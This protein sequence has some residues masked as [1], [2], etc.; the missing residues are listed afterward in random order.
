MQVPADFLRDIARLAADESLPRFRAATTVDNKLAAGF[1]PVTEADRETERAIR[2]RINE[3]YPDHGI[4]GEEHG[5][6]NLSSSHIWII[7]PIDGTRAFISGLPVWG[8]L[9]GLTFDGKAIAGFMSQP[10]TRE[11]YLADGRSAQ[12]EGPGGNRILSTSGTTQLSDAIMFTTSPALYGTVTRHRFDRLEAMVRLSRYGVDCYAFA[13]VAAGYAD[14]VVEPDLKPYD[15]V[16]LIPLIEQAG[17]VIT[18]WDG[19]PAEQGGHVVAA[20][21]AELHAQVLEM[22]REP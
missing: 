7:D 14:I 15:V 2:Q 21:T 11:L 8:T 22:L 3:R 16:A 5:G 6:E 9:V 13:M 1:D 12:Y 4:L 10:F 20:A 18:D 19:G 17:G